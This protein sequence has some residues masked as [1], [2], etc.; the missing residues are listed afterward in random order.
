MNANEEDRA[1]PSEPRTR[2]EGFE[3]GM[4]LVEWYVGCALQGSATQDFHLIDPRRA[5]TLAEN[6]ARIAKAAANLMRPT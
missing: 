6:A 5:E 1:F 2:P 4:T 3:P